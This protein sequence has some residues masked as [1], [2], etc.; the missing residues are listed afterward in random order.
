M[1]SQLSLDSNLLFDETIG[2]LRRKVISASLYPLIVLALGGAVTVFL[3]W[4]V[5]PR[6]ALLYGQV[7]SAGFATQTLMT[8]SVFIRDHPGLTMGLLAAALFG[9]AVLGLDGAIRAK[10]L[11]AVSGWPWLAS[12]L[13]NLERARLFEALSLLVRGGYG[14]PQALAIC[15]DVVNDAQGR[16]RVNAARSSIEGGSPPADSFR[17]AGLTDPITYRLLRAGS[18]GGGYDKVL[19]AVSAR[20]SQRFEAFVDRVTRVIEPT[21]LLLVALVVG[22]L[23]VLLYMPIFDIAGSVR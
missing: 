12:R 6:F 7:T 13:V 19:G 16:E 14:L 18:R 3:L 10:I 8:V 23:V 11:R 15:A 17:D 20:H 4:V 21:L 1:R 2:A 9:V 22:S 5:V